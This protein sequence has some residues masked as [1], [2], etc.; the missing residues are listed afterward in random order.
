MIGDSWSFT[1][2]S[3][4]QVAKVPLSNGAALVPTTIILSAILFLFDDKNNK[5]IGSMLGLHT[6]AC[7]S[8]WKEKTF[9][10]ERKL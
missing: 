8:S 3:L 6:F 10:L 4:L 7:M 9:Y 1:S 5:V 2:K